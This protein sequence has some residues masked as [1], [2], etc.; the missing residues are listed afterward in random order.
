MLLPVA[1]SLQQIGAV[2]GALGE[3]GVPRADIV[4]LLDACDQNAELVLCT[5]DLEL[6]PREGDRVRARLATGE[7]SLRV[8]AMA[9][10][11]TVVPA[12][13]TRSKMLATGEVPRPRNLRRYAVVGLPVEASSRDDL[14]IEKVRRG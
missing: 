10:S 3:I 14:V 5:V 12:K 9:E 1:L 2:S 4:R 6:P 7:R 13:P 8:E 11:T